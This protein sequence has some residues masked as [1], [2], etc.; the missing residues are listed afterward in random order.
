MKKV[1][2]YLHVI[3]YIV[4]IISIYIFFRCIFIIFLLTDEIEINR[5]VL[6]LHSKFIP[7]FQISIAISKYIS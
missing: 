5:I 6:F 2:H 4:S 3:F 1:F 7:K